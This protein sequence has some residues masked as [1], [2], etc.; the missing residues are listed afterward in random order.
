MALPTLDHVV[1]DVRESLD[2][3]A[4]AYIGLGFQ[5]TPR[6]HHTLGSSN[7]LAMFATNYLELLGFGQNGGMRPE[8]MAFPAGLNGLV[9]KTDDAAATA[10]R[11]RQAGLAASPAAAF[12]RPVEVDGTMRDAKFRT[13]H[14]PPEVSGIGRVYF[15][16]H[17]TPELV[18]RPAWQ[19]HP[20]GARQVTRVLV[21]TDDPARQIRLFTALFGEDAVTAG[22]DGTAALT[23]SD[24]GKVVLAPV[25]QI[26][27]M[28]GDA[29]PDAAGRASFMAALVIR[30]P[31]A[32]ETSRLLQDTPG[33]QASRHR[34]IVPAT[35]AFNTTL[36]FEDDAAG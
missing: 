13:T 14:L 25:A 23:L 5:L 29:A 15:C 16:E 33:V 8:L 36:I 4:S 17:L 6:G 26:V 22:P 19:A 12:S 32:G 28:L 27:A 2:A 20:N 34:V 3:A 30:V 35:A 24:G 1:V 21:A 9:F 7:N 18:W 10:E 31:S 11:A